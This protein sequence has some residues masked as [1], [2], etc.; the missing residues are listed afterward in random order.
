MVTDPPPPPLLGAL[1]RMPLDAVYR[2]MLEGLHEAGFTDLVAAHLA[3]LRYP[4]PQGRRPS[5][6]AADLGM[7]RQAVNYLLGELE[8]LG[9]LT[10]APDA[11]DRR[12]RRIR[13]T[14]RGEAV[15]RTIR[16]TV[17]E[18]ETELAAELGPESL[19]QLR[20]L[21][22]RLNAT[23][24]VRVSPVAREEAITA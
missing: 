24:L 6:L 15:R 16:A 23:A 19:G 2:R 9:Y 5:E 11:D 12:S 1:M 13:L 20:E 17:A 18:I 7:S 3:V 22:A 8:R 4:G 10:R 14:E 21:L